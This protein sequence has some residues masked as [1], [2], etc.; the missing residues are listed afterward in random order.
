MWLLK[1]IYENEV[2]QFIYETLQQAL[3][4][5]YNTQNSYKYEIIYLDHSL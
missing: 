3:T 1:I 5:I 2:H 4:Y